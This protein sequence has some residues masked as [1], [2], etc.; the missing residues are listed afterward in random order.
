MITYGIAI[1]SGGCTHGHANATVLH[2]QAEKSGMGC[3]V[4]HQGADEE[5]MVEPLV[6]A[7]CKRVIVRFG[8]T[9]MWI[10]PTECLLRLSVQRSLLS[11]TWTQ[12]CTSADTTRVQA[13]P[14]QAVE[15]WTH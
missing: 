7:D 5:Q 12:M 2:R 8:K 13:H 14:G 10:K 1:R 4:H 6:C 9:L 15:T 3:S 11:V